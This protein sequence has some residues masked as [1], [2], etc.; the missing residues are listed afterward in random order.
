MKPGVRS[1]VPPRN[2]RHVVA[3][4]NLVPLRIPEAL[5]SYRVVQYA[6]RRISRH[7]KLKPM[8][9]IEEDKYVLFGISPI[10]DQH[11]IIREGTLMPQA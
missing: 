1:M 10:W 3:S 8:R 4:G 11:Q 9:N 2:L 7:L 5:Y 6:L